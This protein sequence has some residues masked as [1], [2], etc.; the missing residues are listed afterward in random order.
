[1]NVSFVPQHVILK[2]I[3]ILKSS[4]RGKVY[5]YLPLLQMGKLSRDNVTCPRPLAEPEYSPEQSGS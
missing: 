2:A 1:M 3:L 5:S 4:L